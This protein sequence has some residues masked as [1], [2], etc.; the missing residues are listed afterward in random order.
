MITNMNDCTIDAPELNLWVHVAGSGVMMLS[1]FFGVYGSILLTRNL[2]SDTILSLVFI[3]KM[4][5]IGVLVATCW[6]YFLPY[7]FYYFA[8]PCL[9]GH[10]KSYGTCYVGLCAVTAG[11][12]IQLLDIILLDSD[13]VSSEL[14]TQCSTD[15]NESRS[16]LA[17][18]IPICSAITEMV[19][20]PN[21]ENRVNTYTVGVGTSIFMFNLGLIMGSLP[22]IVF[23]R[24]L[25]AGSI[26]QFFVSV[27][28][29]SML[30][31]T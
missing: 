29:G 9:T 30:G 19:H 28:M 4:L 10:W 24:L 13:Y 12:I 21:E 23:F 15:D 22:D 11:Y 31:S 2:K 8:R 25:F 20:E 6:I 5:G 16:L 1:S 27:V 26:F 18:D 14:N 17:M 7:A 3:L